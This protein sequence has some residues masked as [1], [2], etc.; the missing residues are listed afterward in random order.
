MCCRA[1][2]KKVLS[3]SNQAGPDRVALPISNGI[4]EIL[5]VQRRRPKATLPQ[6]ADGIIKT[7]KQF[8]ILA[9]RPLNCFTQRRFTFRNGYEM[10]MIW[11][12]CIRPNP[13]LIEFGGFSQQPQVH[14]IIVKLSKYQIPMISTM[15]NVVRQTGY[16][17]PFR[18]GHGHSFTARAS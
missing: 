1:G 9:V 13:D 6:M 10:H 16:D 8:G 12:E 2:P 18:S 4:Q 3:P 11:H 5:F 14:L 15:S 7:I 17:Y